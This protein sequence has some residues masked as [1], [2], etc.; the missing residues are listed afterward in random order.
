MPWPTISVSIDRT[1]LGTTALSLSSATGYE[2]TADG[3]SEG[4]VTANNVYASS[5]WVDG[6]AVTASKLEVANIQMR[7][8]VTGTSATDLMTRIDAI[9]NAL[10][11][12]SFSMT[13]S[14]NGASR[15]YAC[16][17][18]S[19]FS[20]E[21]FNPAMIRNNIAYVSAVVPRQP[22]IS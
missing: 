7:V 16:M 3:Y 6:A 10:T 22:Q 18:A 8:K 21:P 19:S 14:V 5:R 15:V 1:E 20:T 11:Q 9:R 2:I 12:F 13:V 4:D 17:A